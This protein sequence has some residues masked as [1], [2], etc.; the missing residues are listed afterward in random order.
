MGENPQTPEAA[1]PQPGVPQPGGTLPTGPQIDPVWSL[2]T[3]TAEDLDAIMAIETAEF[4]SDAWSS[5]AMAADLASPHTHYLVASFAGGPREIIGYAGLFAPAG[6][7]D[8]DIQTIAVSARARRLGIGRGLMT[9]LIE[10]ARAQRIREIFLEVR[11]DKP[12]PRTLY[13]DLG[14]EEIA[15]RPGY[16]QPDNVTAIVMRLSIPQPETGIGRNA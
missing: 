14:F 1:I 6:G 7:L 8:A 13:R 2:R 3:A 11:E 9:A 5:Q 10:I 15:E 12:A 16:Y 4:V